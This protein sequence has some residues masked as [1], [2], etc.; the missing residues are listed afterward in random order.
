MMDD[1]RVKELE[2]LLAPFAHLG[3]ILNGK[4]KDD[5]IFVGQ[6]VRDPDGDRHH[7]ITFGDLRRA[8]QALSPSNLK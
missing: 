1:E 7:P 8:A 4:E 3:S 6:V 2:T 5:A